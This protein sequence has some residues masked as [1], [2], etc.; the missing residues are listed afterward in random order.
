MDVMEILCIFLCIVIVILG[1]YFYRERK[2]KQYYKHGYSRESALRKY[3]ERH[4][5]FPP[6]D[7]RDCLKVA[8]HLEKLKA[9]SQSLEEYVIAANAAVIQTYETKK[10][11]LSE[12]KKKL[13][14][15][16]KRKVLSGS[17][18]KVLSIAK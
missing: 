13:F 3:L 16:S 12:S 2:G 11:L 4:C 8:E 17:K 9:E 6:L 10:K 18:K 7:E 5:D 14:S 1:I 15:G